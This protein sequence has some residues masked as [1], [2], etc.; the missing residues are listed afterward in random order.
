MQPTSDHDTALSQTTSSMP[1][2]LARVLV[3]G[4][5]AVVL[6]LEILAGRLMAPYVGVTLETFT[7]IIGVVLAGIAV[8]AWW[9]GRVADRRD[10]GSFLGPLLLVSAV[11][12][13]LAPV[14]TDLVGPWMRA[15]G[16]AE[17]VI[18]T[19]V[20][21]LAPS[22]LLSAVTPLVIKLRLRSLT[23][24]GAVVGSF[25]AVGTFG[26]LAGTFITG[27][28]LIASV[29]TRGLVVALGVVVAVVGLALSIRHSIAA[30]TLT[31]LLLVGLVAAGAAASSNRPCQIETRYFCA[32][33][34]VDADRPT[35]RTLWLDTLRHSYVDLE[36]PTYI[37]FRYAMVVED[38]LASLPDGPFDVGYVGG[39][40]FTLPRYMAATRP[41]STADV[42]EIDPE[43]VDLAIDQLGLE[44][45]EAI[46]VEARD[47]RMVLPERDDDTYDLVVGDAFGGLSVPWHLTTREFLEE[48]DR[49]LVD[50]GVYLINLLD[51]PPL[52]FARAEAATFR[53]VFDHV[54][55]IAPGDYLDR[56][57]G[58]NF[59]LVGSDQPLDWAD[60]ADR[61]GARGG[62]EVILS[63]TAGAADALAAWVDGADVLIDDFAPVDQLISGPR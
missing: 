59:V 53:S 56:S 35:G 39:G 50:G 21:F 6:V 63:G 48:I 4:S 10:P 58:G 33:V 16:P 29:P 61:I 13:F 23:E 18:L 31:G 20:A 55:V 14:L 57:R 36:D 11:F 3:F 30:G 62:S 22:I 28:V 32:V 49:T 15:A 5:S 8:G 1:L 7:G 52:G 60:I 37:D 45:G 40:G 27:F 38:V 43:L 2:W 47:A 41:G 42:F 12:V 19:S 51:Y 9:G 34:E 25:S 26:A 54:A 17:I 44:L 24:T 46:A